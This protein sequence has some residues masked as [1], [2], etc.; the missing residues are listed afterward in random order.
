MVTIGHSIKI[1]QTGCIP[2]II[3]IDILCSNGKLTQGSWSR[4]RWGQTYAATFLSS[5]RG[6]PRLQLLSCV[7]LPHV[8]PT[9]DQNPLL[10]RGQR[11]PG[12][13]ATSDIRQETGLSGAA[14]EQ[15]LGQEYWKWKLKQA[16]LCS[17][18]PYFFESLSLIAPGAANQ[19]RLAAKLAL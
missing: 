19:T 1:T 8:M 13:L 9:K 10:G 2:L 15:S 5:N 11:Y 16:R 14:P 17:W 12:C 18:P 6:P 3:K 7:V 4:I